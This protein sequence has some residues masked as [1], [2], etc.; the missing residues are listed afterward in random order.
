MRL[1]SVQKALQ[2]K[3]ITFTYT[4]VEGCGSIDFVHRGLGYHIW[5]YADHDTPSGVE[6]NLLHAGKSEDVEGDY[7]ATLC[8]WIEQY[9]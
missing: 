3:H 5:E 1:Q 4:E 6:T 9:F 2:K 7:E 8:G